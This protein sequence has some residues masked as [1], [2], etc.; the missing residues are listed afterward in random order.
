ML[1]FLS[2]RRKPLHETN[3][4]AV[5]AVGGF[6]SGTGKTSL[7]CDL[8]QSFP[9][10][11]AIKMALEDFGSCQDPQAARVS[12]LLSHEPLVR[13]DRE[14]T[15]VPGKDTARYWDAGASNVHWVLS[16]EEQIGEGLRRAL[17]RVTAAGV[18][19]EGNSFTRYLK[20]DFMLMVAPPD[21]GSIKSSARRAL[22][23]ATALYINDPNCKSDRARQRFA[24]WLKDASVARLIGQLP[25]FTRE[26]MPEVVAQVWAAQL[27]RKRSNN[28]VSSIAS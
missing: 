15:Y 27:D 24:S 22:E 16:S 14:Q 13:S 5:I 20:P 4:P 6:S 8:L 19:I 21:G 26:D 1:E 2:K 17:E 25:I 7:I 11:E 10:W 18:F 28:R 9:D 3:L 12:H 23:L